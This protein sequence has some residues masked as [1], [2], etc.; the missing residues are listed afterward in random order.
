MSS[1]ALLELETVSP[2]WCWGVIDDSLRRVK[3]SL[4]TLSN[5][6]KKAFL[7]HIC[8]S[9]VKDCNSSF[10]VPR[11]GKGSVVCH[12]AD[13]ICRKW[14]TREKLIQY[15]KM[16]QLQKHKRCILTRASRTQIINN[17]SHSVIFFFFIENIYLWSRFK[18]TN[19]LDVLKKTHRLS[20]D[21]ILNTYWLK[22][23]HTINF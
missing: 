10:K 12:C 17:K 11:T 16:K 20:K 3:V 18:S 8:K 21:S 13:K 9:F 4:Y 6:R 7:S 14:Y 22:L 23:N 15:R 1:C 2:L 5:Q 19:S